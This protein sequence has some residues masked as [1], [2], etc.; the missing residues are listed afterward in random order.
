MPETYSC[1]WGKLVRGAAL[2][3][4]VAWVV[5]TYS[6]SFSGGLEGDAGELIRQDPRVHAA[7]LENVRQCFTQNYWYPTADSALYRPLVTLTFLFNYALRGNQDAAAGYH[8]FNLGLHLANVIL[9]WLLAMSIWR[10]PLPAFFT[11]ALFALH[12]VN[13]EAVTNVA[14]RADL[15][16]AL[17]VLGG[18]LLHA[19]LSHP[20][21]I[22]LAGLFGMFSKENAIVLPAAMLL[23]DLVTR[24]FGKWMWPAYGAALL[25]VAAFLG[26]RLWLLAAWPE[27][28]RP[29]VDNPLYA[30]DFL[31]GRLTALNVIVRDL[32]LLLWPKLLSWDYSYNQIPLVTWREGLASLALVL[33]LFGVSVWM[34]RRSAPA[35]FFGVFFF[36]ALFPVSNLLLVIGSIMAERFLYLPSIGFAGCVVASMAALCGKREWLAALILLMA[37]SALTY[38]T[39]QRNFEW[40]Q[41]ELL[42]SSGVAASPNSFKTHLAPIY[43]MVRNG[44]DLTNVD[45][46]IAEAQKAVSILEGLPPLQN[47][48]A[49]LTT[50]ASLYKWKGDMLVNQSGVRERWYLLSMETLQRAV[51]LD[52]VYSA[53]RRQREIR[54]GIPLDRIAVKGSA[55]LYDDLCDTYRRLGRFAEAREA[56]VHLAL[57]T[58]KNAGVYT[59]MAELDELLMKPERALIG[60]WQSMILGPRTSTEA[61]FLPLYRKLNP[62]GCAAP[63]G[64]ATPDR[65]CPLVRRHLC[66]A[67]QGL[68]RVL[69]EA[70]RSD[71]AAE[72]RRKA[73]EFCAASPN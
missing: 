19:R 55:T 36:L 72:F 27:Q 31:T 37:C 65:K 14:G 15:M 67:H 49:P 46:A 30:A 22:L 9:A 38:R 54:R 1:S 56:L 43:G 7:T 24:R 60:Y 20:A 13:V 10:K 23:Y 64:V 5:A 4:L 16:A 45:H 41:G 66:E 2:P 68:S 51:E 53:D 70:G 58:P 47:T 35:C 12:P 32:K 52:R 33:A 69:A 18:L 63:L 28:D 61:Q 26:A 40:T 42:W 50:L 17:G 71:E 21:W 59:Q 6:N 57:L 39:W 34:Y 11:A 25:S 44:I 73:M 3:I 8:V 62:G 48:A 29:F